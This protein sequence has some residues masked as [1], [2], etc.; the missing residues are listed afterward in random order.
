MNMPRQITDYN[1]ETTHLSVDV[2]FTDDLY[3]CTCQK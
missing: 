1:W 2:D 3:F